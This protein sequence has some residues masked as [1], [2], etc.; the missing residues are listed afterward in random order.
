[1]SASHWIVDGDHAIMSSD[2]LYKVNL[3]LV[4]K[5][6]KL[7]TRTNEFDKEYSQLLFSTPI[8]I[9][10]FSQGIQSNIFVRSTL[11]NFNI[12]IFTCPV[13]AGSHYKVTNFTVSDNLFPPMSV[14]QH[15]KTVGEYY[16]KVSRKSA[17]LF[18]Y[19]LEVLSRYRK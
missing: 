14:E 17:W 7:F 10:R 19:S 2:V 15:F 13:S 1:M 18:L 4:Q 11:E 9:C 5:R 8:D 16:G 6:F 3:T 12:S